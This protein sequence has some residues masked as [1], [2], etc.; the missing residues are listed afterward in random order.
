LP[1]RLVIYREMPQSLSRVGVNP[2]LQKRLLFS[3]ENLRHA[4]GGT[5]P[6]D[7]CRDAAAL[8]HGAYDGISA[9]CDIRAVCDLVGDAA[10]RIEAQNPGA[11]L[12]AA[13]KRLIWDLR[14]HHA[15]YEAGTLWQLRQMLRGMPVIGPIGRQLMAFLRRRQG[16]DR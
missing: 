12:S 2:F 1:E 11:D 13:R 8:A 3:A 9:H 4:S 7:L 6:M 5:A 10:R 16:L 15:A 14:D